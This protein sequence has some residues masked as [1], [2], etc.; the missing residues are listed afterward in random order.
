M[1]TPDDN[2]RLPLH[3]ALQNN[4]RL[5]SIKLLVKGNLHALHSPDNSGAFPLHIA[6]QH[7]DSATVV[8]YLIGRDTATLD[9][10]DRDGNTAL[11]CACQG[12]K[13]NTIAMFLEKY[14][15]V[16]VSRRNADNKLPIELLW[17]CNAVEDRESVEYTDSI[18][19][20]LEA[21]PETLK[22]VDMELHAVCFGSK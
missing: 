12:A 16:S 3:R 5:G 20:L 1:T 11:H 7:N 21:Y 22:I 15:A 19:Q 17:E 13:Y 2:G 18:F 10:V 14:D 4:V 6:C 8:K 9:A